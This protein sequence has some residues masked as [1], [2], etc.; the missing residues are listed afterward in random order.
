MSKKATQVKRAQETLAQ[1]QELRQ[2]EARELVYIDDYL[3][4]PI[5][6]SEGETL[7]KKEEQK[8][9]QVPEWQGHPSSYSLL[10]QQ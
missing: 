9:N 10:R 8:R 2:R 4:A 6:D 5:R 7:S 3:V 1:G